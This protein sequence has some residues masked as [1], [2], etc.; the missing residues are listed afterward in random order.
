M[1][2]QPAVRRT[3]T[4]QSD[5]S[6][7]YWIASGEAYGRMILAEG[8]TRAEAREAWISAAAERQAR[9]QMAID[10]RRALNKVLNFI[11]Y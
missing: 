5:R 7:V 3:I 11:C 2:T 8:Q 6:G 1:I 4:P 9:E 10:G